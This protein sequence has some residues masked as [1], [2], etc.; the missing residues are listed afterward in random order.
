MPANI[1]SSGLMLPTL[2]AST[3]EAATCIEYPT[4]FRQRLERRHVLRAH[5]SIATANDTLRTASMPMAIA[6]ARPQSPGLTGIHRD[7]MAMRTTFMLT[8]ASTNRARRS[9]VSFGSQR[10]P[11]RKVMSRT[12]TRLFA[13]KI[14]RDVFKN[15]KADFAGQGSLFD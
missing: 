9:I 3:A 6:C 1:A 13:G 12:G 11:H 8:A 5:R 15:A 2:R 7:R 14:A 4:T 10:I